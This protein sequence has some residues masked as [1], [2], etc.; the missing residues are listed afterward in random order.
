MHSREETNNS[1]CGQLPVRLPVYRRTVSARV[2]AGGVGAV[3]EDVPDDAN[4][5]PGSAV[6]IK[7]SPVTLVDHVFWVVSC[8]AGFCN[9]RY[10]FVAEL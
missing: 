3:S 8:V 9:W 1:L 4:H 6:E 5:V 7:D 10:C 2:P